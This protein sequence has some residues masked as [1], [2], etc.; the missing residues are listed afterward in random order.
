[1]I[2]RSDQLVPCLARSVPSNLRYAWNELERNEIKTTLDN[3]SRVRTYGSVPI[4]L[5]SASKGGQLAQTCERARVMPYIL[6]AGPLALT[7]AFC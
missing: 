7:G 1:M 2:V 6:S 3:T 5:L 4:I